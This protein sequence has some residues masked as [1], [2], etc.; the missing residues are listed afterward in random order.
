MMPS[1]YQVQVARQ[2]LEHGL[3][4]GGPFHRACGVWS[5]TS[6]AHLEHGIIVVLSH[7]PRCG[8][9]VGR[10]KTGSVIVNVKA[11]GAGGCA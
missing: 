6:Q 4:A 11:R 8:M 1:A 7:C 2:A 9:F 3:D 10:R 5:T